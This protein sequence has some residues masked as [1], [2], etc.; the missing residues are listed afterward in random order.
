METTSRFTFNF[1]RILFHLKDI[2]HLLTLTQIRPLPLVF[3][4]FYN[5][6]DVT[7]SLGGFPKVI[8]RNAAVYNFYKTN[9]FT[10]HLETPRKSYATLL[11]PTASNLHANTCETPMLTS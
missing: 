2:F 7:F 10:S 8:S 6:T 1:G 4:I 3:E 9:Q 11:I 5:I